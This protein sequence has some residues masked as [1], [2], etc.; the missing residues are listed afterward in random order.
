MVTFT[1]SN[2]EV[3]SHYALIDSATGEVVETGVA[4]FPDVNLYVKPGSYDVRVRHVGL[5]PFKAENWTVNNQDSTFFISQVEDR[6]FTE[7]EPEQ[8]QK[9]NLH[10]I[11]D[12]AIFI[13]FG[14]Q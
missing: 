1:I 14:S 9:Q 11:F 3:G 4:E 6:L 8:K 10:D 5:L 7:S 2:L 12:D 13:L